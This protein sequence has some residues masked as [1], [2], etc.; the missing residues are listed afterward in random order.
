MKGSD[1]NSSFRSDS[2]SESAASFYASL[3]KDSAQ[4]FPH[5]EWAIY[6]NLDTEREDMEF[7]AR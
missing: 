3:F 7:Q 2:T 6:T 1:V 5:N 4:E